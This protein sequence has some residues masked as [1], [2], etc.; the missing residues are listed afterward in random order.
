MPNLIAPMEPEAPQDYVDFVVRTV[1][2]LRTEATRLVGGDRRGE[3]VYTQALIDVAGRWQ[4]LR[5][6]H[7]FS[8]R[9][10]AT[11]FL[12]R[13][14]LARAQQWREDQIYP[15]EVLA[16]PTT[17]PFVAAAP[18]TVPAERSAALYAPAPAAFHPRTYPVAPAA[19]PDTVARR[20]AELLPATVR[21]EAGPVAEAGIAWEHAYRLH[22]LWRL[23]LRC[24]MVAVVVAEIVHVMS[25]LG[26]A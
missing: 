6:Q 8:H 24:G 25:G 11:D 19:T 16:E 14:L 22:R 1:V 13:R 4:L 26:G 9:D 5:W 7:R 2:M 17:S 12:R 10:A 18:A 21:A 3:Q 20:L 15:V 23:G